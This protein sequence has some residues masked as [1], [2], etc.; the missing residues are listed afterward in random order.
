M[1]L[2]KSTI[3]NAN[4]KGD[5]YSIGDYIKENL[6]PIDFG[7]I[8]AQTAKQVIVNKVREAERE[9]NMKNI[10]TELVILY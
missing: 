9:N 10:K 2:H 7:R 3:R 1:R 5:N 4:F 6:P 8:A